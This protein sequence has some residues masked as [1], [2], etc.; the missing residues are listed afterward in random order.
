MYPL[1]PPSLPPVPSRSFIFYEGKYYLTQRAGLRT[2]QTGSK[3]IRCPSTL[4]S[5]PFLFSIHAFYLSLSPPSPTTTLPFNLSLLQSPPFSPPPFNLPSLQAFFR[6]PPRLC[7]PHPLQMLL[8]STS[9]PLLP[10]SL[11]PLIIYFIATDRD[12]SP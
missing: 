9:P 8:P 4:H 12:D 5:S 6:S 2:R 10:L 3:F 1:L 11:S 7:S